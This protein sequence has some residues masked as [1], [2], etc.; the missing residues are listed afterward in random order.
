[1]YLVYIFEF[2]DLIYKQHRAVWKWFRFLS[3]FLLNQKCMLKSLQSGKCRQF[4]ISELTSLH[5]PN[6]EPK[7]CENITSENSITEHK[8]TEFL[9]STRGVVCTWWLMGMHNNTHRDN[10]QTILPRAAAAATEQTNT[11]DHHLCP[12]LWESENYAKFQIVRK[13]KPCPTQNSHWIC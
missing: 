10:R 6:I 12:I 9:L 7:Q 3:V 5:Q 13:Q 8:T 1:M 2:L 4:G 11:V